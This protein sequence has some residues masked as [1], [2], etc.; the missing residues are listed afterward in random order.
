[1]SPGPPQGGSGE[2]TEH[3]MCALKKVCRGNDGE[4]GGKIV[5]TSDFYFDLP[6]ELIA[7]TPLER[8]D[9]SRLLTLDKVTGT[10]R[11]PGAARP[12]AGPPQHRR[13]L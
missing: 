10:Q 8:R 13:G 1:M 5:K 2:G 6:E 4:N 3:C 9:A 12:S 7:Q 11:Q